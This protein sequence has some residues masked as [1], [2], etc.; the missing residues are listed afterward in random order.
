M[1]DVLAHFSVFL[2][3]IRF[4]LQPTASMLS[5][6]LLMNGRASASRFL[7]RFLVSTRQLHVSIEVAVAAHM[8]ES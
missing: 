7:L 4:S 3:S 2:L 1:D 6:A 5:A 8:L